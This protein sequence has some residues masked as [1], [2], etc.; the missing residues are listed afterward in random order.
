[1]S[2]TRTLPLSVFTIKEARPTEVFG[3]LS[4]P[5]L[6]AGS[7]SEQ[8]MLL[9]ATLPDDI[10]S[11]AIISSA[12][13]QIVP[14]ETLS[15]SNTLSLHRNTTRLRAHAKWNNAP[16]TSGTAT[17]SVTRTGSAADVVWP[18]AVTA[19]V[20][21]FVSG[22]KTNFGWRL[23]T[24][25]TTLRRFYGATAGK[26]QPVLVVAYS[27]P[28]EPPTDLMPAGGAV[29][30]A[31]PVV[32]FTAPPGTVA[33]QVQIDPDADA[34]TAWES[35]ETPATAGV[36]DLS[37]TTYPGLADGSSTSQRA[38]YEHTDTGWSDWCDWV[39]F[40]RANQ[41][42]L[43]ITS[44]SS[45]PGD[46]TPP[47]EWSFAG[48]TAWRA[49]LLD[50]AGRVL[51]DSNVQPGADPGWTP[52]RGLSPASPNGTVEVSARDAVVRVATPGA[53]TWVTA[54]QAV[55]FTP[56]NALA[57][58]TDFTA[59][60]IAGTPLVRLTA[61]R[62]GGIPDEVV[63]YR[64]SGL[65]DEVQ[66]ARVPGLDVMTG[67]AFE[68]V[69]CTAP[70]NLVSTYRLEP[71]TDNVI[72][73]EGPTSTLTVADFPGLWLIRP[74]DLRVAVLM[75]QDEGSWASP[76]IAAEHQ[77]A[78][79]ETIR[80]RLLRLPPRGDISGDIIDFD[81]QSADETMA[82]MDD[83]AASDPGLVY[84][85]VAGHRNVAVRA[86]EI[87]HRPTP[88][89]GRRDRHAVGSWGFRVTD[90]PADA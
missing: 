70:P 58:F 61:T 37:A 2:E 55:T 45:T 35:D 41:P 11:E 10:P 76:E 63:V 23:S 85:Y 25:S 4:R 47:F 16:P 33:I 14:R 84:R 40:S 8:A 34:G 59:V 36:L 67:T 43:T 87:D 27:V 90:D 83:F 5:P 3:Q 77:P 71:V 56:S 12:E 18:F 24:D 74:S 7:G 32:T 80:R 46:S 39:T 9:R 89:S 50:A 81:Y 51:S 44:P 1:M 29:S 17:D 53:P 49:R 73:D 26:F 78:D 22:L 31:K 19:D 88:L 57:A 15:G 64:Q 20:Q 75:G 60:Q 86:H 30:V 38:R 54:T 65:E 52:A 68:Y 72:G 62:D 42:T 82:A 48:Q 28:G 13:V 21:S 6:V 79:G 66:V 69:D